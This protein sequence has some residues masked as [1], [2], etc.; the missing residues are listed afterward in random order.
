MARGRRPDL[1][2][3]DDVA[4]DDPVQREKLLTQLAAQHVK[5][6]RRNVIFGDV[7][8]AEG[9]WDFSKLDDAVNAAKAHGIRSQ[10]TLMGTPRYR[11][12]A[13]TDALSYRNQS[14]EMMSQFAHAVAAHMGNRVGRYS[15]GN[16]PNYPAFAHNADGS[17]V[18]AGRAYRNQYR[19]GR[20]AIKDV[21]HK[22][23]VMLGE[24][25]NSPNAVK[26][27]DAVLAGKPL[28]TEGLALHPYVADGAGFDI[29]HLGDVQKYLAQQK[30]RG[31]LQTVAGQQAPLYLTEFG[32]QRG[33]MPEDQ[34][35]RYLANAYVKAQKAG[36]RE[37]LYYQ[38]APSQPKAVPDMVNYDGSS[39]PQS[40]RSGWTWD[41]SPRS[42]TEL[43]RRARSAR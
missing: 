1:A 31:R 37:L 18:T 32:K 16:E 28:R 3:Q 38:L 23:A 11:A 12:S 10:L 27:M 13:E 2:V 35:M 34:R 29:N 15:I 9:G 26:F 43:L 41:T 20:Q 39:S 6:Q 21:N 19:A 4:L 14:P 22:A 17:P 40:G 5:Y 8:T 30:R 36:A 42:V 24:L 7:R 33:D 25:S